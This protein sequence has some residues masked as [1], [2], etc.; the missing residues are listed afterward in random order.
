MVTQWDEP[1]GEGEETQLGNKTK[2]LNTAK[3]RP[4]VNYG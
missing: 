1:A 4:G 2:P 3:T